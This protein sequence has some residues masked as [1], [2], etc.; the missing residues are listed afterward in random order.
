MAT[1]ASKHAATYRKR[2]KA[3]EQRQSPPHT[4]ASDSHNLFSDLHFEGNLSCHQQ[5]FLRSQFCKRTPRAIQTSGKDP[6]TV[7]HQSDSVTLSGIARFQEGHWL[8]DNSINYFFKHIL[9]PSTGNTHCYSSFFFS[10]LLQDSTDPDT[11]DFTSVRRWHRRVE[12]NIFDLDSLF[13]PINCHNNHWLLMQVRFG[14][15]TVVLYDSLGDDPDNAAYGPSMVRYLYGVARAIGLTNQ[16]LGQWAALWTVTTLDN[17][18]RQLNSY[19]CGI[20]TMTTGALLS[21]GCNINRPSYT[22]MI[23]TITA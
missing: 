15:K 16:S 5:T 20:F 18:P 6:M 12:S 7:R 3:S 19:D 17:S 10:L 23:S 8:S 9:Q 21:Q 13:V 4:I 22:Q 2:R 14:D 1:S 11:F